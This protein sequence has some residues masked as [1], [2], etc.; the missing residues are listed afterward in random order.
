[1]EESTRICNTCKKEQVFESFRKNSLSKGGRSFQCKLCFK[2]WT[3]IYEKTEKGFLMRVY[4]N[5]K[6][7][8]K[9]IQK[10][11]F[12]LYKGKSL[13]SKETFYDWSKT[14]NFSTLFTV[15][16]KSDYQMKLA[17]SIDRIDASLGYEI[18][19]IRWVTHSENSRLGSISRHKGNIV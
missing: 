16:V 9:G 3:K 18:G 17:P 14:S 2:E 6:S 12:H 19:N 15:Y 11:K 10:T 8:I 7:R 13:L 4:R 5:M 1:M